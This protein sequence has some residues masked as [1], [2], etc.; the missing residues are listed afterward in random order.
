MDIRS[1]L[2]SIG[3]CE[4]G[5]GKVYE[6]LTHKQN[7]ILLLI[8][9]DISMPHMTTITNRLKDDYSSRIPRGLSPSQT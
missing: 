2:Y 3:S 6:R 4:R 9:S 7:L 1:A 5:C 8:M